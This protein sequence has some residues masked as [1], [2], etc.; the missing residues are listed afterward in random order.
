[1]PGKAIRVYQYYH[2]EVYKIRTF[3]ENNQIFKPLSP[4]QDDLGLQNTKYKMSLK[5]K[6]V[7]E[8]ISAFF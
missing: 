5:F 7:P 4:K 3:D 1:M 8:Y 6:N 2:I